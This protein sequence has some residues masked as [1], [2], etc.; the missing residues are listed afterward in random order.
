MFDS[1]KT[2]SSSAKVTDG[3]LVLTL[4]DAETP[5]V[6]IMDLNDA[7]TSVLRLENDRQGFYVIKKHGGKG[8]A[9]TVAVYRDRGMA[10]HA[11]SVASKAMEKAR[12]TRHNTLNGR[13]VIVRPASRVARFF[14]Y[15]LFF[16]FVMYLMG[17]DMYL[18]RL[19]FAPFDTVQMASAPMPEVEVPQ[20]TPPTQAGVPMSAD[21]FLMNQARQQQAQSPLPLQ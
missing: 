19:I 14:T 17:L 15:F 8:A 18:V 7:A 9:E 21:D 3:R 4:T 20:T 11:L 10:A 1:F 2:G 13:P 6:W 12:D 5:A 16:W